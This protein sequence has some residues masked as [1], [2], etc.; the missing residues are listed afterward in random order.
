MIQRQRKTDTRQVPVILCLK[1]ASEVQGVQED[2]GRLFPG[3]R[4][5]AADEQARDRGRE[6]ALRR[7]AY[8]FR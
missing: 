7:A 5:Q 2:V 6:G 3:I 1:H 8:L 4:I